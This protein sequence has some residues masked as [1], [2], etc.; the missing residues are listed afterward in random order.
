MH[1]PPQLLQI[2]LDGVD[3]T[4]KP[5]LSINPTVLKGAPGDITTPNSETSEFFMDRMSGTAFTKGG[6]YSNADSGAHTPK[7]EAEYEYDGK[8]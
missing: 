6:W 4:P 1:L 8:Q 7:S 2:V 3:R 5:L